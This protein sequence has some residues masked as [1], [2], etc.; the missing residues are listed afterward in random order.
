MAALRNGNLLWGFFFCLIQQLCGKALLN[1]SRRR[2]TLYFFPKCKRFC[3]VGENQQ[4]EDI[5]E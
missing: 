2:L 1:L 5:S 4:F 3:Q